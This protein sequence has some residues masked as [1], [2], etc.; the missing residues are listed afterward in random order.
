MC[1]IAGFIDF[2]KKSSESNLR[3]M[4]D[5]IPHRGPDDQGIKLILEQSSIIG[6]AHARL[7]IIDLSNGGHQPM[8]YKH[9]TI[10]FNGEIYNYLE[11]KKEL[12][13]LGHIFITASDTEVIL[14]AFYEWGKQCVEKFI[15]MFIYVIFDSKSKKITV[16]RDRAGVKPFYYFWNEEI[17]LFGSELKALITHPKFE[18]NINENIVSTYFDL[19]YIPAPYSI[20]KKTSK[21]EPGHHLELSTQTKKIT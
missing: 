16:T 13:I 3:E 5:S 21:I 8:Q 9:L 18:K 7:S 10:V 17:F 12:E 1:G 20:F 14:H 15:G 6:L 19:G 11:I 4:I 2:T